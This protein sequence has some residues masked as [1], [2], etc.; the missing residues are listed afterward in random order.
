M[1]APGT[2]DTVSLAVERFFQGQVGLYLAFKKTCLAQFQR[3]VLAFD[4]ALLNH[5]LAAA[6]RNAHS[7]KTVLDMLGCELPRQ[8]ALQ[9]ELAAL[10][11]DVG[12]AQAVWK[13][14]REELLLLAQPD[15]ALNSAALLLEPD[16]DRSA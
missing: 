14:L 15:L 8:H 12:A 11:G 9:A 7:L 4:T 2:K 5:D 6:R 10:D 13:L 16:S 3:D 1:T